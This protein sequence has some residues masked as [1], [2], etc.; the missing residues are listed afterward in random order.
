[1]NLKSVV[2]LNANSISNKNSK[3]KFSFTQDYFVL[4]QEESMFEHALKSHY[5]S[6]VM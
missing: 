3:I 6:G 5:T 4:F 2:N 1:M